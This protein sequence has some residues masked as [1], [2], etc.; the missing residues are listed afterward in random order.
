MTRR[1]TFSELK[2]VVAKLST[3][4]TGVQSPRYH[5]NKPGSRTN[6]MA[7]PDISG[8]FIDKV[9]DWLT[10]SS[11]SSDEVAAISND[12]NIV[13]KKRRR[14][15][16]VNKSSVPPLHDEVDPFVRE[17]HDMV[18]MG[19]EGGVNQLLSDH[20]IRTIEQSVVMASVDQSDIT[21]TGDQ[22]DVTATIDQ[23]DV[24][25][26]S[27]INTLY[28]DSTVLHK[29]A[30]NGHPNIVYTLLLHGADPAIRYIM[31]MYI[32]GLYVHVHQWVIC[33]C[34]LIRY[35]MYMYINGLY[36]HVH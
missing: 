21:R 34:T 4:Y 18:A 28:S 25:N 5:G 31:Y 20:G 33:T 19:D 10:S 22:S 13:S 26:H 3:I 1:P 9:T 12:S 24:I 14:R 16:K 6:K 17:L 7:V 8:S 30:T 27:P 32:N 36:V 15:K 11:S 23:S 29:A 2:S 35:I